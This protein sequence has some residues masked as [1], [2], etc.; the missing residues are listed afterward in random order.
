MHE[1]KE[2]KYKNNYNSK[3]KGDYPLYSRFWIKRGKLLVKRKPNYLNG[4]FVKKT[5]CVFVSTKKV[6]T[7]RH[8]VSNLEF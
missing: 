7:N 2:I 4:I 8:R 3:E 6:K 5:R 1:Q